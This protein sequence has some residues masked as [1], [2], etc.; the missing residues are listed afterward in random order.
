MRSLA[1]VTVA[2][3]YYFAPE[4]CD[5]GTAISMSVCLSVCLSAHI[6]QNS[7]QSKPPDKT[8]TLKCGFMTNFMKFMQ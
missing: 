1:I 2:T 3:C 8:T 7:A 4:E 6:S 5:Q